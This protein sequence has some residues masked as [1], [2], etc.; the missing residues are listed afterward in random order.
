MELTRT[1]LTER[2]KQIVADQLQIDHSKFEE[3]SNFITDLGADSLDLTELTIAFE[4]AFAIEIPESDL[5]SL[6]SVAAAV[7][8]LSGKLK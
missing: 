1:S 7:T 5:G 4:D 2:V 8:Y 3:S 6:E